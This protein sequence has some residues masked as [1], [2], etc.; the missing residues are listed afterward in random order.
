MGIKRFIYNRLFNKRQRKAIWQAVLYSEYTYKRR[1]NVDAAANVRTVINETAK[2]AATKQPTFLASEVY[3]IVQAEVA[4]ARKD[5]DEKLKKAYQAGRREGFRQASQTID[6]V[7]NEKLE[8]MFKKSNEP[9][10]ENEELQEGVEIDLEKCEKCEHKDDCVLKAAIEEA[11]LEDDADD[12]DKGNDSETKDE[13][14]EKKED[15]A[16]ADSKE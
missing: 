3:S 11:E 4:A 5:I 10:C 16:P 13:E 14:P 6:K 9:E 15:A 8:Q 1:G 7:V 12:S 2:I